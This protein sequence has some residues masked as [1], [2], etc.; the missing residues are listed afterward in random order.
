MTHMRLAGLVAAGGLGLRLGPGDPK[1]LRHLA[2][3]SLV[4][5]AVERLAAAG[6]VTEVVVAAP[7]SH[8]AEVVAAVESCVTPVPVRVVSGGVLRQDSVR[9]MLEA[10]SPEVSHVLVHDAARS[11]APTALCEE[12][13]EAL[14]AGHPAVIPVL[15]VTDTVARVDGEYVIGNVPRDDLR[16]VQTPQGFVRHLLQRAHD[17]CPPGWEAT[18]DASLVS[19]LGVAVVTVPGD[20]RAMKITTPEDFVVA[21]AWLAAT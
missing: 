9:S 18:D 12:V 13:A 3:S 7:T 5:H 16:L 6:A 14:A 17:E 15:P 1:G 4:A 10:L 8:Y 20:P 21:E 2:G 11:L 19:R